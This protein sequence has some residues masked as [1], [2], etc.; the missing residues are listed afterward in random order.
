MYTSQP[1]SQPASCYAFRVPKEG[2]DH[3]PGRIL[4]WYYKSNKRCSLRMH[5]E[6]T[7]RPAD[8]LTE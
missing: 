2:F 4:A 6:L 8:R 7:G 1:D 5:D 3:I